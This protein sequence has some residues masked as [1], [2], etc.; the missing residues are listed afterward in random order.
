MITKQEAEELE[1]TIRAMSER[2]Y[3]HFIGWLSK[4]AEGELWEFMKR[5]TVRGADPKYRRTQNAANPVS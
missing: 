5:R 2:Q 4:G 3:W 1:R